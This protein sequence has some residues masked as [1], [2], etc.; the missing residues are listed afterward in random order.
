MSGQHVIVRD[1]RHRLRV[2]LTDDLV[3][4]VKLLAEDHERRV[5]NNVHAYVVA[6]LRSGLGPW[7][8]RDI[9]IMHSQKNGSYFVRYRQF[10][11][12]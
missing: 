12:G 2:E 9:R 1:S 3:I 4:G 10:K 8:I 11:C 5:Q 6:D 7:R